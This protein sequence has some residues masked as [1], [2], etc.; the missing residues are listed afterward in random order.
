MKVGVG[1]S[2]YAFMIADPLAVLEENEVHVGFSTAFRDDKSG[3]SDTLL[4]DMNLLVARMPAVLPSD[5]QKVSLPFGRL[6]SRLSV[7]LR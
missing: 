1:R 5:V 2:C 7:M 3:F 6:L 4:N